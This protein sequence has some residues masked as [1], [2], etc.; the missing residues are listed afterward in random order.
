M[1][2]KNLLYIYKFTKPTPTLLPK[3]YSSVDV[4]FE[5]QTRKFTIG[6]SFFEQFIDQ[7]KDFLSNNIEAARVF[8]AVGYIRLLDLYMSFRCDNL[9][10]EG[11][12]YIPDFTMPLRTYSLSIKWNFWD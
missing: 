1:K 8:S 12:C 4:T 5:K 11:Y 6:A 10:N 7:R 3:G 9:F 2:F